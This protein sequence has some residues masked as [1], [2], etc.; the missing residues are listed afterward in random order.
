MPEYEYQDVDT[1]EE[2]TIVEPMSET[3]PIGT[4]IT[5]GDRRLRKVPPT[6][7]RG[8]DKFEK[9]FIATSQKRWHPAASKYDRRGHAIIDSKAERKRFMDKANDLAKGETTLH[10]DA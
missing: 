2:V 8:V 3:P 9:P 4:V 7:V 10:W 6:G 1:G 5:R